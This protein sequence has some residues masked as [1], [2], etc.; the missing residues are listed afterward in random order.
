MHCLHCY[1]YDVTAWTEERPIPRDVLLRQIKGK[2]A[3]FCMLT[4]KIDKEV[5]DTA[6]KDL[7]VIAT[8]SV[9]YD[10]IDVKETKS[11]GIRIGFTPE[12]LTDAVAELTIG[13]ILATARRMFEAHDQIVE[14][15]WSAWAPTWMCGV[16]LK[17]S[18]VGI[19]GFGRI[20]QAVAQRLQG[21]GVERILYT[22]RSEKREAKGLGATLS[23]LENLVE[24]S[25]FIIV[26]CALMPETTG[27]FSDALFDK[28]KPTAIFI[29]TSRGAVVDQLAL[30]RALEKGKILAAGIDVMTPEPIPPTHPLLKL[31]NCGKYILLYIYIYILYTHHGHI[32]CIGSLDI[33]GLTRLSLFVAV[34][35]PHIGSATTWARS[36]MSVMTARNIIAALDSQVMPAEVM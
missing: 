7:R 14:G 35:L 26:T 8:M 9:G 17:R 36:Q 16:E 22:S 10:H 2:N 18:T 15:K 23:S 31:K 28:M 32:T 34:S 24:V 25:D 27:L 12:V 20:G 30:Q 1:R 5:L 11:R 6:G 4:D 13:L 3:L 21:F 33:S 29:N 19:V